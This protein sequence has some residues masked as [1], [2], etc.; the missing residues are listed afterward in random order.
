[1]K[2]VM[3]IA[4]LVCLVV[5]PAAEAQT[6][7]ISQNKCRLDKLEDIRAYADSVW[8]PIAQ[9]LVNEGSFAAVGSA[10]HHW[11]DEWNVVYWYTAED[12]PAFLSA[13]SELFSR[14][15]ERYPDASDLF[16]DWCFEHKDSMYRAGPETG[17]PEPPQQ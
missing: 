16:A 4:I 12:I 6:L 1:M 7:V 15:E 3:L 14:A 9:E 8:I 13:F 5:P 11:G 2:R 17:P 10:F